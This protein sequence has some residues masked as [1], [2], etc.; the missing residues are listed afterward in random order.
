MQP[1]MKRAVPYLIS[2]ATVLIAVWIR[3]ILIP[4]IGFVTPYLP[5]APLVMILAVVYSPG[6]SLLSTLFGCYLTEQFNI[7]PYTPA[8][9]LP[10][11]VIWR[12]SII[13]SGV[14]LISILADKLKKAKRVAD[15]RAQKI[16]VAKEAAE[17]ANQSKTKF[18]AA[19]SH[20]LRT[21]LNAII[22]F[23][24]LTLL[25][26]AEED[27][28]QRQRENIQRVAD[29]G[30]HL[31]K[32]MEGL[33]NIS[34]IEAGKVSLKI[35]AVDLGSMLEHLAETYKFLS[36]ERGINL[37]CECGVTRKVFVDQNRL[38]EVLNNLVSNAMKY[39]P[40]QGTITL[41]AYEEGNNTIIF[42]RDTG[43]GIEQH[44][45]ERIFKPFEQSKAPAIASGGKSLGL[46][47]TISRHLVELHGGKLS[48]ES[49]GGKGS[50]FYFNLPYRGL[51]G[52]LQP[53]LAV[54][55]N[56]QSQSRRAHQPK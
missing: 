10:I 25:D 24:E 40:R 6:P 29:A 17:A 43:T 21:P 13:I 44:D 19:M 3:H 32:L 37:V 5:L 28:G 15:D 20:D 26:S 50:C 7:L 36:S 31:L 48:V 1:N 16:Q 33:L 46:G 27:L 34:A 42:V 2:L 51:S 14:A 45:L 4:R 8:A 54:E 12:V 52:G 47:L 18:M 55:V 23:S 38:R 53:P 56:H 11:E 22:G 39:T 41:G 49:V 9:A 30:H 35:E